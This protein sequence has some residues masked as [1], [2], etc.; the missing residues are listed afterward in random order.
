MDLSGV[1]HLSRKQNKF[2]KKRDDRIF[3]KRA[4]GGGEGRKKCQLNKGGSSK[5]EQLGKVEF[6]QKPNIVRALPF[7]V[8]LL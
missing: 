8:P 7:D 3:V 5:K 4:A 2:E 1:L 6:T